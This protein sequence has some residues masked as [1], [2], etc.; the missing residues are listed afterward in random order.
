MHAAALRVGG[1]AAKSTA[2]VGLALNIVLI[3]I[4]LIEI[5]R[6]SHR[7]RKGKQTKAVEQLKEIVEHLQQQLIK[8]K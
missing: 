6:S 5:A 8:L 1:T 4:N 7:L 3:P 2:G